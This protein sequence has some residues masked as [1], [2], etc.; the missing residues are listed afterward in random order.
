MS[1]EMIKDLAVVCVQIEKKYGKGA[2]QVLTDKVSVDANN[3]ISTSSIALDL[4]LGI[5]GYPDGRIIE[6]YGQESSGKTTLCLHAVANEQARGKNCL[7][8]DAEHSL[9]PKYAERLG[10]NIDSLIISQP[11]YGEQALDIVD[12]FVRSGQVGLIVVDSVAALVPQKELEGEIGDHVVGLQARMMSQA[13]RKLA[14]RCSQTKCTIIFVNQIRQKIGVMFGSPNTTTGGNALK[15]Y[16]SQRLEI[17]R[18]G[19]VK[20]KDQIVGNK[21]LVKV[22]KNKMAPP[23]QTV[24]FNILFGIGIDKDMELLNLAVS[25]NLIDKSGSWYKYNGESIAQGEPNAIQWLNENSDIK[26]KIFKEIREN[27]GIE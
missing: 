5:G 15:F 21:T 3:V 14:G 20:R 4:A 27:R 12:S 11:D 23:K 8:I 16:A 10:V 18:T 13:M 19:D 24:E 1:P 22:I 17:I 6:I 26:E 7:Y 25:D 9:D 2:V